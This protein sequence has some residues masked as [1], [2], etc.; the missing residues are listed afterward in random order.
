MPR[1]SLLRGEAMEQN[2]LLGSPAWTSWCLSTRQI[3]VLIYQQPAR[4]GQALTTRKR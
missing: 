4:H 1:L 2:A 3:D